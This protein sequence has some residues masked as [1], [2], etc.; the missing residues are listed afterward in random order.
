MNEI[1]YNALVIANDFKYE[2]SKQFILVANV[3]E[4]FEMANRFY[5]ENDYKIDLI[6]DLVNNKIGYNL[7]DL[8]DLKDLNEIDYYLKQ[9]R[10]IEFDKVLALSYLGNNQRIFVNFLNRFINDYATMTNSIDE[11]INNKNIEKIREE[12]HRYKGFSLYLG[13]KKLYNLVNEIET[14]IVNK[15]EDYDMINYFANYHNRVLRYV[16]DFIENV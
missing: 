16:K 15:K 10:D 12:V 8:K 1:T 7:T 9:L 3:F 2:D 6:I 4:S 13:S 5:C 14:D 11:L